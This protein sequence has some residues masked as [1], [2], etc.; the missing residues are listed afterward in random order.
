[1]KTQLTKR[2]DDML[3]DIAAF[4]NHHISQVREL[5]SKLKSIESVI[6]VEMAMKDH[7]FAP[8]PTSNV[9]IAQLLTAPFGWFTEHPDTVKW[10]NHF[11]SKYYRFNY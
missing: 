6:L 8:M 10:T 7:H 9:E 3:T 5:Y 4:F 11:T 2:E 1:M